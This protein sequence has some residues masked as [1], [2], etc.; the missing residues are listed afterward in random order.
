MNTAQIYWSV[1]HQKDARSYFREGIE[2]DHQHD[3]ICEDFLEKY[4]H[5]M[6]LEETYQV[7][8]VAVQFE[9]LP[10]FISFNLL[11]LNRRYVS[12]F[13][14]EVVIEFEP[15]GK[16]YKSSNSMK[17]INKRP[18]ERRLANLNGE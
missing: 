10:L 3:G 8:N 9:L 13:I 2:P 15:T 4:V 18:P 17:V 14:G 11:K 7:G 16:Q 5:H 1:R 12:V 6:H